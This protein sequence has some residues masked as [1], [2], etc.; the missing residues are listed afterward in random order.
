MYCLFLFIQSIS[1]P[2]P[3]P[4]K[5][6]PSRSLDLS[7]AW[8]AILDSP[9]WTIRRNRETV[10]SPQFMSTISMVPILHGKGHK[11][12]LQGRLKSKVT[13]WDSIGEYAYS[14][15][16]HIMQ[17]SNPINPLNSNPLNR[18]YLIRYKIWKHS[19]FRQSDVSRWI[20]SLSLRYRL[21]VLSFHIVILC[22]FVTKFR[23][24]ILN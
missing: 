1:F 17:N 21:V 23:T 24:S 13:W 19:S 5:V 20:K 7:P 18:L 8:A 15:W 11:I 22:L 4:T 9:W 2:K 16:K 6:F 10:T 14:L 3:A 12:R